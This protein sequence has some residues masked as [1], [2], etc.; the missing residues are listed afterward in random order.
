MS[1]DP[2]I[3][4]GKKRKREEPI[5]VSVATEAAKKSKSCGTQFTSS[6]LLT[7]SRILELEEAII[8]SPRNYNDLTLLLSCLQEFNDSVLAI[9]AAVSLCRAFCQLLSLGRMARRKNDT[10]AE[11]KLLAWLKERYKEYVKELELLMGSGDLSYQS[12]ALTLMMRLI[13]EEGTHLMAPGNEY[14]FPHDLMARVARTVLYLDVSGG[15]PLRDEFVTKW[16]NAYHDVR[17]SFMFV[18]L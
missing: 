1:S 16:L 4:G 15:V 5:A 8:S 17:Y 7:Q 9:T 11:Q 18:T 3:S 10:H 14:F 12:T 6:S 2:E 13:K